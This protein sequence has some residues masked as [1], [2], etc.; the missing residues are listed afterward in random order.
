MNRIDTQK[1]ENCDTESDIAT[2][3]NQECGINSN[4]DDVEV[5]EEERDG[6]GKPNGSFKKL[7]KY[8]SEKF[9]Q[10]YSAGAVADAMTNVDRITKQLQAS[11]D[12]SNENV[13]LLLIER[14]QAYSDLGDEAMAR[15]DIAQAA[16][17]VKEPLY[18]SEDNVVAVERAFRKI[19]VSKGPK[20]ANSMAD[21]GVQEIISLIS[22]DIASKGISKDT[23]AAAVALEQRILANQI[24]LDAKQLDSL[25]SMFHGLCQHAETDNGELAKS[26]SSGINVA[27]SRLGVSDEQ[28]ELY[29]S[30][31]ISFI[32]QVL[33]TWSA[34][35]D[36]GVFKQ[37]ACRYGAKMY[38]SAIHALS[39]YKPTL[40]TAILQLATDFYIDSIWLVGT[41][42]VD[43]G[44]LSTSI[45]QGM[46]R[47][48]TDCPSHFIYSYVR[49][50]HGEGGPGSN[51]VPH[52]RLLSLL[53]HPRT[54][55]SNVHSMAMLV[56]SQLSAAVKDPNNSAQFSNYNVADGMRTKDPL[57][58]PALTQLREATCDLLDTWIQ[59]NIQADRSRGILSL[60]ALYE[61]GSGSDLAGFLWQKK[62]WIEEL[63]DQGEFDKPET[64]LSLLS[65][66]D[67]CSTDPKLAAAMKKLGSGLV[68]ALARKKGSAT[69]IDGKLAETASVV[70]A[71]WSSLSTPAAAADQT[72]LKESDL[73]ADSLEL[74]NMHMQRI[75][76]YTED[77]L[78]A[79]KTEAVE[80]ATESLGYL[81]LKPELKEHVVQNTKLLQKLFSAT[82]QCESTALRFATTMLIRNLTQYRPVLSEEQ[83]RMQQLQRLNN[84]AA[85]SENTNSRQTIGQDQA[86]AEKESELD[87]LSYVSKR[88]LRVC[89]EGAIKVLVGAV[90]AKDRA[91]DSMKDAVAETMVSLATN[92]QLRGQLVQQGA[93]RALL[94]ILTGDAPKVAKKS[95]EKYTPKAL[96]Q[97]RD[98]NIAFAIAKIAIS[99]PPHLAFREPRDIVLLLLSLL[100]EDSETQSL[101]MKFEALLALTN[102]ASADPGSSSDVRS[103]MASDLNGMSLIELCVLSDHQLVRRAAT[104]LICN[105]V[106]SPQVFERFVAD[107][108]KHIKEEAGEQLPSGIV[109]L[110]SDDEDIQ[111]GQTTTSDDGYRAQRLHLLVALADVDD[112]ATRSAASG[113]LAVLSNDPRCCRYLTL[114]HPR[115]L[116]VLLSLLNDESDNQNVAVG[117]KHR[118][119]VVC[120]NI[121]GCGDKR[122]LDKLR[123]NSGLV[124]TLSAMRDPQMPYCAAAKSAVE[125]VTQSC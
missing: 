79:S 124:Q 82:R 8:L 96:V 111:D 94:S 58:P 120:A 115:A 74:A 102:L 63:W 119:A 18:S 26:L 107:A 125:S 12:S 19:T 38:T 92:Q 103:Y 76:D 36:N 99:V 104:E 31:L 30:R 121:A 39:T 75:I 23:I 89:S 41:L 55:A 3:V 17:L 78:D 32:Q 44:N 68:Q 28:P 113:A 50:N 37:Q 5:D 53:G 106:Y 105:L 98:K 81:C 48:L 93:V 87:G 109:E 27:V 60:A 64:Q 112:A 16:A 70:L 9:P 11:N 77:A 90:Q 114:A 56:V 42:S 22:K 88:C 97:K 15:R 116:S 72:E 100:A 123:E 52:K 7:L 71:K 1:I 118:A 84:R 4:L 45:C 110:P 51:L 54:N 25:Q 14:A 21:L 2:L 40:D 80:R 91:S 117:I 13:P 59:S 33:D 83:K 108:E 61:S 66:A 62:G 95:D 49:K 67:A 57:P 73:Q 20:A 10:R 47:L 85:T 29:Q 65:L 122:V 34:N 24:K 101:L 69:S 6:D 46:L 35:A 43:E 86:Q